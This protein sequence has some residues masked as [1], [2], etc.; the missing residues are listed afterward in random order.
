M[1]KPG[2]GPETYG[3]TNEDGNFEWRLKLKV[4]GSLRPGLEAASQVPRFDARLGTGGGKYI[5][6]LTGD[7]GGPDVGTH[8]PLDFGC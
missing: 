1:R 8:V 4:E 3:V 7:V 2:G 5:N 6:P